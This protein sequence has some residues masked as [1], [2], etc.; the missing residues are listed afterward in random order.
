VRA[1][2]R[3]GGDFGF[4]RLQAKTCASCTPAATNLGTYSGWTQME[5][6]TLAVTNGYLEFGL[7]TQAFSGS[8]FVHLDTVQILR[9]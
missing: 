6:P 4:S 5:T 1:W 3:K 8:S 2:V 9:Q 7:H